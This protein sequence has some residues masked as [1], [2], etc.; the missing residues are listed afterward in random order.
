MD[1]AKP[2]PSAYRGAADEGC[3]SRPGNPG[4]AHRL[5]GNDPG[6]SIVPLPGGSFMMG[7]NDPDGFPADGEGPVR[8]VTL[9]PFRIDPFATT[10]LQFAEFVDA[11]GYR[12]DAE[13]YGWS[14]VF[15][16]V[17]PAGHPPTR[18]VAGAPWWRQVFGADR[19]H[20]EG[21]GSTVSDRADHPVVHVSWHDATAYCRWADRRLPTEAEWECA[22]RGGLQQA[23]YA[24]GDELTPMVS[25]CATSGKAPFPPTTRS[26]TD[27]SPP[28]PSTNPTGSVFTTSPETYGSGAPTG[29]A[30]NTRTRPGTPSDRPMATRASFA[31]A[32]TFVTTRAATATESQPGLRTPRTAVPAI[33]ASGAPLTS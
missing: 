14:F 5:R 21:P 30:L 29:S 22:A 15:A 2:A 25:G 16:G 7:G 26:R 10:N 19:Q 13:G 9:S 27:S 20:P 17:V 6:R 23:R 31:A 28:H 11:T 3:P 1:V 24:W 8:Q 33:W 32:R 12:T 18:G 4:R